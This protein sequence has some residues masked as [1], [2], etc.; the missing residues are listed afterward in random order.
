MA[1]LIDDGW[2]C[3]QFGTIIAINITARVIFIWSLFDT[4]FVAG[5]FE[6]DFFSLLDHYENDSR[7]MVTFLP[8]GPDRVEATYVEI[9]SWDWYSIQ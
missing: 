1:S 2:T 8:V 9:F 6:E 7:R 4:L 5:H 3:H